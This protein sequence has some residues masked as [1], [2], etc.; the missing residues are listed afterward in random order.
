MSKRLTIPITCRSDEVRHDGQ[1]EQIVFDEQFQGP[2]ERVVGSQR[3]HVASHQ[4]FGQD[5]RL[6]RGGLRGKMDFVQSDHAQEAIVAIDHGQEP[7]TV[8]SLSRSMTLASESLGCSVAMPWPGERNRLTRTSAKTCPH[9][10]S[11]MGRREGAAFHLRGID[12]L[13]VGKDEGQACRPTATAA[14]SGSRRSFH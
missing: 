9:V 10:T 5:E 8:R 3:L 1:R 11:L 2:I 13:L 4:V 6:Q 14:A 7:S 12:G